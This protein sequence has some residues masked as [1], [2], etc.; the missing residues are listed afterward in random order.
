MAPLM[1]NNEVKWYTPPWNAGVVRPMTPEAQP[2]PD[3]TFDTPPYRMAD[4]T[5]AM[6]VGRNDTF[7]IRKEDVQ[8]LMQTAPGILRTQ[9][10]FIDDS[11]QSTSSS[12][13][14][15]DYRFLPQSH[16]SGVS[17]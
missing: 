1:P 12:G 17:I 10:R 3:K 13:N 6:Q 8:P 14:Q 2:K 5:F 7:D 11:Q 16:H 9:Q 4:S 15:S